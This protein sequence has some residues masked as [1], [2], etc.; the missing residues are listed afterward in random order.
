[1]IVK[2]KDSFKEDNG[3][4]WQA[5][6]VRDEQVNNNKHSE[7]LNEITKQMFAID[8]IN[9]LKQLLEDEVFYEKILDWVLIKFHE[10]M[11]QGKMTTDD[12]INGYN[13][14]GDRGF[15][16]VCKTLGTL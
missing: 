9:K 16:C 7:F 14:M 5:L 8:D 11:Q 1:M 3:G 10:H 2:L 15:V 4:Y 13:R 6:D 12:F